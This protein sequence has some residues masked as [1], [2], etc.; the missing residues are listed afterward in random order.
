M[1]I[2]LQI[3]FAIH[4]EHTG[5]DFRRTVAARPAQFRL[6]S[7]ALV[8]D[9]AAAGYETQRITAASCAAIER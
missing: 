3:F 2:I 7:L 1:F 9:M 4:T 6:G 8:Y 5:E